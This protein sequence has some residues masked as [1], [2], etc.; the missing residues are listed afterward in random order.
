VGDQSRAHHPFLTATQL[1][2]LP[3]D[4]CM[5]LEDS[6]NGVRSAAAAGMTTIMV[7]DPLP[8]TDEIRSLSSIHV[9]LDL[10]EVRRLPAA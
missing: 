4:W 8:A 3:P 10:H 9:A 2:D 7:P 6:H 5:A 1:L